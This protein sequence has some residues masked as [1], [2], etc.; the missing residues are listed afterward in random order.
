[1]K[2]IKKGIIGLLV[3][4][5]IISCD[6]TSS[7]LDKHLENGPI[8]YSAKVNE[9][10]FQSG[11]YRVRVNIYPANDVNRDFCILKWNI[12]NEVKDSVQVDY[13]DSNYDTDLE[14]YYT[15]IDVSA[16]KIQGNLLIEA[17]N[18]DVFGNKSLNIDK[19]AF[20]YG[21]VYESTLQ[22]DLIS[23]PPDVD[24]IIV[25]K[26][27]GSVGSL[28]SYELSDGTFTEEIFLTDDTYPLVD[29]KVGGV[30]RNKTR[31]LINETD[32]DTLTSTKYT[33]TVIPFPP[34]QMLDYCA[35][36]D[37][38]D[39]IYAFDGLVNANYWHSGYSDAV[40]TSF[41]N[42]NS[43]P[44]LAHYYVIDYRD[45]FLMNSIAIYGQKFLKTVEI[46]I[47]NDMTYITNTDKGTDRTVADYWRIPHENTWTKI[48]TL[49]FENEVVDVPE[50]LTFSSPTEF[51]MIMVILRDSYNTGNGNARISE[52]ML[53][54]VRIV[55]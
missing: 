47:S 3:L 34:A 43:D 39:A 2:Y 23:F 15:V 19:G 38:F 4:F 33:E 50:T 28:I 55:D 36:Q 52:I 22:N 13:V 17:Q 8:I 37:G 53:D 14:C 45:E 24:Q 44:T 27:I 31:Y 9:L 1:M 54:A 30:V 6:E 42:N 16:D 48:G 49:N 35:N 7:F 29:Y 5:S 26:R 18:V 32:I 12:T 11:Y 20:L 41:H 10:D 46:W 25:S 51:R 21:S 40:H